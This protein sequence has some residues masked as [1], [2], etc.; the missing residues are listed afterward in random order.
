MK[1]LFNPSVKNQKSVNK[2]RKTHFHN[3]NHNDYEFLKEHKFIYTLLFLYLKGK[4][5][6]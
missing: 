2:Y 5:F 4:V 1:H 3:H 6:E